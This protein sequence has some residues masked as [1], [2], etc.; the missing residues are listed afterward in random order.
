[1]AWGAICALR[2]LW[3]P[4]P[5]ILRFGT[6]FVS[7]HG[8]LGLQRESMLY[9]VPLGVTVRCGYWRFR[10]SAQLLDSDGVAAQALPA[11]VA[12]VSCLWIL[13]RTVSLGAS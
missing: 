2:P 3:I 11:G 9:C 6:G 8:G 10:L 12:R 4:G 5:L 13:N 7:S 1:M